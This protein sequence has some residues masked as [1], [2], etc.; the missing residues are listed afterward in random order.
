[1]FS[2]TQKVISGRKK[3]KERDEGTAKNP[4]RLYRQFPKDSGLISG[5]F[6]EKIRRSREYRIEPE[7]DFVFEISQKRKRL[8]M[9]V[10]VGEIKMCSLY[11]GVARISSDGRLGTG[12]RKDRI[13]FETQAAEA[14]CS[15]LQQRF[16]ERLHLI[17][18]QEALEVQDLGQVLKEYVPDSASDC[19]HRIEEGGKPAEE[20]VVC[21]PV[22]YRL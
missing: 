13:F 10:L 7:V 16:P 6:I 20:F 22:D 2:Y 9:A 17:V 18:E 14:A 5:R 21:F 15:L 1:M 19:R 12:R 4:V 3:V 8:L 11:S